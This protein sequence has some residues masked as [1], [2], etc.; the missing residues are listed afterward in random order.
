MKI[1]WVLMVLVFDDGF[2]REW[3]SFARLEECEEVIKIITHHREDKMI[4]ICE[5]K[6]V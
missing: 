2:W 3:K 1:V 5:S 4:A 6:K